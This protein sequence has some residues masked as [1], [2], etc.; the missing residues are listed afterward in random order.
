M[1]DKIEY[2]VQPDETKC[3]AL[4]VHSVILYC[5][6][7]TEEV[8]KYNPKVITRT[9]KVVK[10]IQPATDNGTRII[11][12]ELEGKRLTWNINGRFVDDDYDHENDLYISHRYWDKMW[13]NRIKMSNSEWC[14]KFETNHPSVKVEDRWEEKA[15]RNHVEG[16]TM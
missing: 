8:G 1:A 5:Y 4:R 3:I 6:P 15:R 11:V 10:H 14:L 13:K 12:G 2:I 16:D 9:G 7:W